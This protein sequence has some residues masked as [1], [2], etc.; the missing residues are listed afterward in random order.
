MVKSLNEKTLPS[1]FS[2]TTKQQCL[3]RNAETSLTPKISSPMTKNGSAPHQINLRVLIPT[4]RQLKRLKP[5]LKVRVSSGLMLAIDH[6]SYLK[7]Q[8]RA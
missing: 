4:L 6:N 7:N 8:S 1:H 2:S 3:V 5:E